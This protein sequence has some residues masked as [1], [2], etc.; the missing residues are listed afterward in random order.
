MVCTTDADRSKQYVP[1]IEKGMPGGRRLK[2][3]KRREGEQRVISM[4]MKE[5]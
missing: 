3:L 2:R 5:Q 4:E 1:S